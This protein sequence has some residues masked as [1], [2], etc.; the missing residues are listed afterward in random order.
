[1]EASVLPCVNPYDVNPI[2]GSVVKSVV[3]EEANSFGRQ[4]KLEME[5][6]SD[7]APFLPEDTQKAMTNSTDELNTP[8][9]GEFF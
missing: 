6:F 9:F 1:M 5:E 2:G 4:I 3:Q 7:L 8:I